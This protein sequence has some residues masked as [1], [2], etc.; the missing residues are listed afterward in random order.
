MQKKGGSFIQN[1]IVIPAKI[2]EVTLLGGSFLQK[3][4]VIPA[5]ILLPRMI[6]LP[7]KGCTKVR[8]GGSFINNYH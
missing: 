7:G 2:L 1:S 5:K 8:R 6:K 4:F 3:S